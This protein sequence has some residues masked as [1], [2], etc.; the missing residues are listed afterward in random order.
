MKRTSSARSY[1]GE[2]MQHTAV[3]ANCARV[4]QLLV[5]EIDNKI[6]ATYSGS[7]RCLV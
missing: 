5:L 2:S 1:H 7:P 6:G 4:L 3:Q